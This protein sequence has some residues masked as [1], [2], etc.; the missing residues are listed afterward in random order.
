MVESSKIDLAADFEL[1]SL[2][3]HQAFFYCR[4]EHPLLKKNN[5]K[6]TD[7]SQYR[8]LFTTIPERLQTVFARDIFPDLSVTDA[9]NSLKHITTEDVAFMK[10][11]VVQ[12]DCL[13][14]ATYSMVAPELSAGLYKALPLVIPELR[15][16]Y[17]II[18]RK[19]FSLSPAALSFID[20]L[21]DT[22]NAQAARET[23][24][25]KLL[26]IGQRLSN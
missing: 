4:P 3:I 15:T 12:S 25:F 2:Q 17:N 11:T 18:K 9:M 6:L 16:S 5:L 26:G 19:G 8:L 10:A 20:V 24:V 21:V 14:I 13:G 1:I 22:D 7:L 23:E